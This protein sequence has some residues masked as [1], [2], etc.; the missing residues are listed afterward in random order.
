MVAV[1][2]VAGL[3]VVGGR[4]AEPFPFRV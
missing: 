1:Y 2:G 3:T 4:D